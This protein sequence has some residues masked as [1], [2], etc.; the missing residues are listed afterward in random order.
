MPRL[1]KFAPLDTIS[2]AISVFPVYSMETSCDSLNNNPLG[3][4]KQTGGTPELMKSRIIA[5]AQAQKFIPGKNKLMGSL[6][7]ANMG[8]LLEKRVFLH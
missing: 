5:S 8:A 6:R 1:Q 4:A 3:S 7:T 2:L